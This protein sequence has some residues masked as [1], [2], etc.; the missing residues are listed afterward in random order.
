MGP[1]GMTDTV[2]LVVG[3]N[4]DHRELVLLAL[5]EHCYSARIATTADGDKYD[6]LGD[7]RT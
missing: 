3:D 6:N 2:I 7:G 4:P 5:R 1:Q